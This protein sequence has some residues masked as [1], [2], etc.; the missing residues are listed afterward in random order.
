MYYIRMPLVTLTDI[1][2][3][4]G[5][6]VIFKGLSERFFAGEKVGLIG[7]NGSGKTTLFKLILGRHEPEI[8][9]VIKRKGLRIGYLPQEP[10]F[11]GELTVLEQMHAGLEEI[12][13]IQ[14]KLDRLSHSLG[15]LHSDALEKAMEEYQRISTQ[16]ELAGG[17]EYETRVHT[18]LAG[19]GFGTEGYEVKTSALSG[20]QLSRLGLALTLMTDADLLLLD[21]PTNHLDLEATIWLEKF[22]KRTAAGVIVISHDRFL[23]DSITGRIVELDQYK[24]RS[25][26]GNYSKFLIDKEKAALQQQR[27]YQKR[28]E[29]VDK[30]RDFVARN[31]NKEGMRGTAL[32]RQKRLDK[33]LDNDKDFLTTAAGKKKVR[34]SFTKGKS[35]SD[36]VL[37]SEELSKS[38]DELLLFKGLTFDL[39]DGERLGVTGPNG[40]GKSTLLKMA[41]GQ[42]EPSGGTI[43]IGASL[44]IGYLDQHA[45]EL[46]PESTVLEEGCRVRLDLTPEKV[47]G[48]LGAFLFTGD[49]V[50]KKVSQLSGGQQNRL[51][52]CKLVLSEPDVLVLDEPTNHLD[53][54]SREM[55]ENA[56]GEYPGAI[57]AVSHDRYFLDKV[58]DKLLIIGADEIGARET[59]RFEFIAAHKKVYSRY[60]ELLE[61]RTYDRVKAQTE[62][63]AARKAKKAAAVQHKRAVPKGLKRFNRLST[64]QIEESIIEMEDKVARLK[65][66]FGD[67]EV[68]KQ[69]VLLE[70]LQGEFDEAQAELEL[71]Y[72]AY[73]LRE[74]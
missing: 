26:K 27:Q 44:K 59:G 53:I 71:L 25:W 7:D 15:E 51:M 2:K 36:I 30:T 46:D 19:L 43:R 65:E 1:H 38:F 50:F 58:V 34:F 69:Q 68:Y 47:R 11:D 72:K 63:K 20:G 21:E 33:L 29:M 67:E 57:I 10:R 24:C 60:A 37:R 64:E 35:K 48:L 16:F 41:L 9:A 40:T 32:G 14:K 31:K 54:A 66:R 22:L 42:I 55:L 62:A 61:K 39:L 49:D 13:S 3:S 56:L 73:E 8:G 28:V 18:V 5:S 52:L 17:Y 45:N 70:Q 4:F 23:L 12:L 6:E 74:A